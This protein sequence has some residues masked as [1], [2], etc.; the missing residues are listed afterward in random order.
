MVHVHMNTYGK[1]L[2]SPRAVL[3]HNPGYARFSYLGNLHLAWG[4][5]ILPVIACPFTKLVQA[6]N[7]VLLSERQNKHLIFK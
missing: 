1:L 2:Q 3:L 5:E 6:L 4:R 7:M